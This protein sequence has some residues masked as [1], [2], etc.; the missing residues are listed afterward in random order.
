MHHKKR[1]AVGA[2]VV[3]CLQDIVCYACGGL[4]ALQGV[5]PE[6]QLFVRALASRM[7]LYD[8]VTLLLEEPDADQAF[9][10]LDVETNLSLFPLG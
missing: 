7:G 9:E 8:G 4:T 1:G 5:S 6:G 3:S 10:T 2:L